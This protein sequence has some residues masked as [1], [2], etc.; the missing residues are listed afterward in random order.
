MTLKQKENL[1]FSNKTKNRKKK[2]NNFI[3]MKLF[4]FFIVVSVFALSTSYVLVKNDMSVKGFVINELEREIGSLEDKKVELELK[5]TEL[6]SF[7]NINSRV[8]SLKMVKAENILYLNPSSDYVA[9]K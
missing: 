5:I 6:E 8:D 4:T 7:I 1:K 3:N 2:I 9:R